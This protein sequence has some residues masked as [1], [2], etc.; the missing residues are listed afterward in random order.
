[1]R[2]IY[3]AQV[4]FR[5]TVLNIVKRYRNTHSH[6]AQDVFGRSRNRYLPFDYW[7]PDSEQ[8]R[9]IGEYEPDMLADGQWAMGRERKFSDL[10]AKY[11]VSYTLTNPKTG[12]LD[13][14]KDEG[15]R[16]RLQDRLANLVEEF[17]ERCM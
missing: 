7:I 3:G 15:R 12:P 4:E 2:E 8:L 10:Y 1:M 17:M 16:Y 11:G 5:G 6:I 9:K 14:S 13:R